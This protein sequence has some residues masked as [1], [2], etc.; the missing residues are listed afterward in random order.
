MLPELL[1]TRTNYDNAIELLTKKYGQPHK[2]IQALIEI[3]GPTDSLSSLQLFYVT[4]DSRVRGL[5]VLGKTEDSYGT[6]L[7]ATIFGKL[8]IN[9][10][11]N[12][13]HEH[14]NSEWTQGCNT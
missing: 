12:L 10:R 5:T 2:I 8:P 9:I 1:F 14:G 4:I 13:A 11:R 6:T 3:N 7:V